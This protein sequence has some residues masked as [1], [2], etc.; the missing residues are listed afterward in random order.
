M[1][2]LLHLDA[3]PRTRSISRELSAAFADSW[4]L[5]HPGA[6]SVAR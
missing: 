2:T 4:R 1:S 5:E 6:V 3:S